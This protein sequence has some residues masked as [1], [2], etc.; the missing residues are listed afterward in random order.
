MKTPPRAKPIMV[1]RI[2]QRGVGAV[3]AESAWTAGSATTTDH[4]PT[5]PMV[6][7]T[8]THRRSQA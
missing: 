1:E 6:D 5:P 8:A 3:D 2:G 7:N 4:I